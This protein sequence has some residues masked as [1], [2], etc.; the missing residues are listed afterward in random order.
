MASN[1]SPVLFITVGGEPMNFY[2]RPGPI[3]RDLQPLI[4]AGGGKTSNVQSPGCIL[5]IDPEEKG[6]FSENTAHWYVSIQYIHDCVKKAE[7][8]NIEDYRLNPANVPRRSASISSNARKSPATP[9]GRQSY[10]SDEDAAILSYVSQRKSEVKGNRLW[11]QMEKEHVTSHPWQ[12]MKDH[13]QRHLAKKQSETEEVE[14][15]GEDVKDDNKAEVTENR[16][17]EVDDDPLLPQTQTEPEHPPQNLS[18]EDLTQIEDITV[19]NGPQ[20]AEEAPQQEEEI[21]NPPADENEQ[22]DTAE[23]KKGDTLHTEIIVTETDESQASPQ[24]EKV[25]N[26]REPDQLEPQSSTHSTANRTETDEEDEQVVQPL[27]KS[28]RFSKRLELEDEPY[29]KKR[30]PSAA[31]SAAVRSEPSS[32]Q[33]PRRTRSAT[34]TPQ[35][36]TVEEPPSKRAKGQCAEAATPESQEEEEEQLTAAA[37][38]HVSMECESEPGRQKKKVL[39]TLAMAAREFESSDNESGEELFHTPSE[40][41]LLP[42]IASVST[43]AETLTTQPDPDPSEHGPSAQGNTQEAQPA[44]ELSH[45]EAAVHVASKDHPCNFE[46]ESQEKDEAWTDLMEGEVQSLSQAQLEEDKQR[47]RELMKNTNQDLVS[48]TK[49]LLKTSGDFSAASHL[50]MDPSSFC[51]PF[52]DR[53]DDSL[54]LSADP[55]ACRKLEK[56]HGKASLAKRAMFLELDQ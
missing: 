55:V 13:Y 30:R 41:S 20:D 44:M 12:S 33:T 16:P 36:D 23:D 1:V 40:T 10:T 37:P 28:P 14:A 35:K 19:E 9:R 17:C 43:V 47:I 50:L 48:V 8:L 32:P 2:L 52:W 18:S 27:R 49:A 34:S 3:K 31:S 24:T 45:A 26:D 11:Q 29:N 39:G 53:R 5:L 42:T 46:D 15:P 38:S 6:T 21:L 4:K 56:K 7:Q 54:L 25:P 22:A 51:G